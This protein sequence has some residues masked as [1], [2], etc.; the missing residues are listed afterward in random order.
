MK[1]EIS[2]RKEKDYFLIKE[3]YS[4]NGLPRVKTIKLPLKN[5]IVFLKR[6]KFVMRNN[7]LN[8]E[9]PVRLLIEEIAWRELHNEYFIS[10]LKDKNK[11]VDWLELLTNAFQGGTFRQEYYFPKYYYPL[12]V[13]ESKN[14]VK[15]KKS[16]IL[17]DKESLERIKK[18]LR[19]KR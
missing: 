8:E 12:K 5:V 6:L 16:R 1:P 19:I 15:V 7:H 13:L 9:V 11:S 2:V 3:V 14:F 17:V 4:S 10:T 18:Y